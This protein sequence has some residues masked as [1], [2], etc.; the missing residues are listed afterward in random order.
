M[1]ITFIS[2][3][4]PNSEEP[5]RAVYNQSLLCALQRLGHRVCAV[6]P[7][8][9]FPGEKFIRPRS[10]PPAKERQ[11]EMNVFHPRLFYTPGIFIRWHYLFYRWSIRRHFYSTIHKFQPDHIIL[12]FIYPDAVALAPLCRRSRI[13]YSVL[14]L[15]SDFRIRTRQPRFKDLVMAT[16]REAPLIFCPGQALKG[17]ISASGIEA[18]KIVPFNNG[19]DH[20]LFHP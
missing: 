20:D 13:D 8:L 4:F 3:L 11:G 12:G 15:G 16:L 1:D 17:D 5:N 2:T 6:A 10:F 7:V 19:L 9:W 14:V 18:D